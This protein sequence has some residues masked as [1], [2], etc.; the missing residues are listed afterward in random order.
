MVLALG[1]AL[2]LIEKGANLPQ[3]LKI[4]V[5]GG[6]VL[7]FALVQAGIFLSRSAL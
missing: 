2:L 6:T 1:T 5:I 4:D 3:R 7:A